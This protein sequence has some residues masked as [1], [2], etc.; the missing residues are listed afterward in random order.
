[1][2][3]KAKKKLLFILLKSK[4]EEIGHLGEQKYLNL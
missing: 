4:Q 1:M 3:Y 2:H